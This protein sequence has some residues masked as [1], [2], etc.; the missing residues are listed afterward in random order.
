[1]RHGLFPTRRPAGA[2]VKEYTR[3]HLN[4]TRAPCAGGKRMR[5]P[6]SLRGLALTAWTGAR[7]NAWSPAGLTFT[8]CPSG[9]RYVPCRNPTTRDLTFRSSCP[10][11]DELRNWSGCSRASLPPQSTDQALKLFWSSIP[12]IMTPQG[13]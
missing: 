8:F 2:P 5:R 9:A 1:P 6:G 12:T 7:Y 13:I 11:G 4:L 3:E 10:R